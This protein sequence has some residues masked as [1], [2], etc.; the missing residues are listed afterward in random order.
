MKYYP[1]GSWFDQIK[2]LNKR[3][4]YFSNLICEVNI[5]EQEVINNHMHLACIFE[6]LTVNFERL[7]KNHRQDTYF[8]I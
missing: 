5:N 8:S 3:G 7:Q 4:T 2:L 6:N 1:L